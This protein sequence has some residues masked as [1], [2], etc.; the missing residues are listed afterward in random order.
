VVLSGCRTGLGTEVRGE[1]LLGIVRAFMDAGAPRIVASVWDV[2]DRATAIF[3][4]AFYEAMLTSGRAPE[5]TT[6][7]RLLPALESPRPGA[8][9]AVALRRVEGQIVW[10]GTARAEDGRDRVTVTVPAQLVGPGDY[11]L[12]LAAPG[13]P[14]DDRAE[15]TFRIVAPD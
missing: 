3:M 4:T 13:T 14:P 12:S 7:L 8:G 15:Y 2:D 9:Y 5:G 6:T 10:Q 1:G 11:V